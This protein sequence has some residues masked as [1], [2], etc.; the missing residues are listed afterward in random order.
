MRGSS[1]V[2]S[3]QYGQW[4]AI[5]EYRGITDNPATVDIATRFVTGAAVQDGQQDYWRRRHAKGQ[6]E[7]V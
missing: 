1:L 5:G 6:P 4:T 3:L 7:L 2:T